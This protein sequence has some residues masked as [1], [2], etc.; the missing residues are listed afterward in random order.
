[1]RI[2]VINYDDCKPQKC[3]HL[4]KR[5]CPRNR[6]GDDC[7]T[8]ERDDKKPSIS[9]ELCIGCGICVKKCPMHAITVVNLPDEL[10]FPIHQYDKNGFRL[11]NLPVP[12]EGKVVGIVGPNGVGK[13]TAVSI[14]SGNLVP[15]IGELDS[16]HTYLDISKKFSGQ[17]LQNYFERLANNEIKSAFKP[18]HVDQIP[19]HSSGKV[20]KLL[21][22]SDERKVMDTLVESLSMQNFLDRK[23]NNLSGGELQRVAIAATIMKDA[24]L[25]IFDEPSSYLDVRERLKVA[26]AIREL[27]KNSSVLVVEH[28]LIVLDYLTDFVHILYGKPMAYGI[29]SKTYASRMGINSY[30]NGYLQEE[31][32]RIR[33]ESLEFSEKEAKR[34]EQYEQLIEYPDLTKSFE[35]FKLEM[36]GGKIYKKEVIGILGPNAT[37]KTTFVK[38]M[39]G[40]LESDTGKV[41]TGLKVSYKPQYL[42]PSGKLVAT[43]LNKSGY[44]KFQNQLQ[45]MSLDELL[46]KQLN[47]LSG[48]ELQRVAIAECLCK[49]ADIYLLDEP[50][51]HLDVEQRT[52]ISKIIRDMMLVREKTALV[53][54]HDVLFSDY[55]SDRL[56]IFSGESGKHGKATSPESMESGMN[57]FLSDLDITMRREKDTKRPRVNKPDSVKDRQQRK[58]GNFY[59]TK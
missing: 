7:I 13:T 20:E 40:V 1:M 30:L 21:K 38:I 5:V 19:E 44:G 31:N 52:T 50:S 36:T 57:K 51:A 18:Q 55:I 41:D 54:D 43:V 48:G 3:D 45:K 59:Y 34:V 24:S 11:Y 49:E 42:V 29:S 14:L 9:E 27:A 37:G 2:A 39:A 8:V 17:E 22:K 6:A 32:M 53:V 28:D 15:N 33:S 35:D 25:Y 4:C 56:V 26:K 10:E 58:S 12:Q 46:T 23:I 16:K 47:Q